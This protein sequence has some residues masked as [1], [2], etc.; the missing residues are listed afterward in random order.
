VQPDA[1]KSTTENWVTAAV[2]VEL[3]DIPVDEE[4]ML[5]LVWLFP[6]EEEEDEDDEEAAVDE[7]EEA[8][9]SAVELDELEESADTSSTKANRTAATRK[10]ERIL[11]EGGKTN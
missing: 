11:G 3:D 9:L 4:V 1:K 6:V 7:E 10:V 8:E 5:L 2:P